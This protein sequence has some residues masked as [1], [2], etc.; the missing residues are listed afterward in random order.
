M[1]IGQAGVA[2]IGAARTAQDYWVEGAGGRVGYDTVTGVAGVSNGLGK[3]R[4]FFGTESATGRS[5]RC[6]RAIE[7]TH[8]ADPVVGRSARDD[9]VEQIR[10]ALRRHQ[11]LAPAVGTSFEIRLES[12][13]SVGGLD[14][15]DGRRH[16]RGNG[17]AAEQLRRIGVVQGMVF[18]SSVPPENG[19]NR[20]K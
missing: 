7:P 14:H 3:G 19:L 16:H 20:P 13:G 18:C 9:A 1:G 8:Q 11:R 17:Q 2:G 10:I 15:V 12:R 6:R 4:G 5:S